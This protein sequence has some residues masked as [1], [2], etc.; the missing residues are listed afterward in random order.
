MSAAE[1]GNAGERDDRRGTRPGVPAEQTGWVAGPAQA[2]E[3]ILSLTG[4]EVHFP[5]RFGILDSLLRRTR[6]IWRRGDGLAWQRK[7]RDEWSR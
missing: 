4:I 7:L 6:G 3:P 1:G 2:G 5:I